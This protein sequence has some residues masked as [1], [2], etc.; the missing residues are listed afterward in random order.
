[1][2]MLI[3]DDD[4]SLGRFLARGL[5]QDGHDVRLATDGEMAIAAARE[6]LPEMAVL[7][8]N[9]PRRDGVEV[10]E[11]LRSLTVDLPILIL[12]ARREPDVRVRCLEIG[13]DDFMV[14]PF[15]FAEL[16]AR[17]R[18]LQRR[19]SPGLVL[20]HADLEVNRID[21]SVARAGQAITLTNKE[22]SLLEY[23]LLHKGRVVPRT[24]LL[25]EVW[26]LDRDCGTNVV[27][28]YV[29]YLRRKL[30]DTSPQRERGS[31]ADGEAAGLIPLIQTVRG[32]GYAIGV[33]A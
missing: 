9:L 12:T 22:F 3:A 32:Q 21:R 6:D 25:R 16:R 30:C 24:T 8:L 20:R 27:D 7:D 28:V 26:N 1:M 18:A 15:S 17:C 14:K 2:R 11:F 10:L 5:E 33:T 19:R 13:A 29:N 4:P 23:L 31:E